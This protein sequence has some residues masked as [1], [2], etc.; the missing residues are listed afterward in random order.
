VWK[1]KVFDLLIREEKIIRPGPDGELANDMG[2]WKHSGLG[3]VLSVLLH[4]RVE[5]DFSMRSF[6]S[7]TRSD[8]RGLAPTTSQ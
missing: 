1:E 8:G 6:H 4:P 7:L 3:V 5:P 2:R